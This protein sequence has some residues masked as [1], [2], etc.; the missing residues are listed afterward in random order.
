[1]RNP[2]KLLIADVHLHPFP[3]GNSATKTG[4]GKRVAI[5]GNIPDGAT[6]V[7][8]GNERIFFP[9]RPVKVR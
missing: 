9:G 7:V 8:R 4:Y 6:V 3:E 2:F 5:V 1:M